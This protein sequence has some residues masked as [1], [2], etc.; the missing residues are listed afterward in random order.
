MASL[1]APWG[2]IFKYFTC[3]AR[4]AESTPIGVAES[5]MLLLGPLNKMTV[6]NLFDYLCLPLSL[7]LVSQ[8]NGV[9]FMLSLWIEPA[10]V[11]MIIAFEALKL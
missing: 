3:L 10:V 6:Q 1:S 9:N 7:S 8:I 11:L 4:M 5:R 2:G